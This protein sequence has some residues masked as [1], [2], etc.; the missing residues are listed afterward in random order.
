MNAAVQSLP[1][2]GKKLGPNE[3]V[4]QGRIFEVRRMENAVY[5]V[6]NTPAP[7]QFS[8]PQSVEVISE[9]LIGKSQEDVTVRVLLQGYRK[10]F[11][12]K[13]G[14]T[15]WQTINVLRVVE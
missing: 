5:T 13:D 3:A 8:H 1:E 11:Q 6:I 7:D 12:R 2:T 14:D 10:K 4:I 15:A 9:R